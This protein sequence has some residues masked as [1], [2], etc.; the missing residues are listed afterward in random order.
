[1]RLTEKVE[2][3]L[4]T[5][6]LAGERADIVGGPVRDYLLGNVPS[7]YDITTSASPEKIKEIFKDH[8]TVDTGIKHGTVSL[9]LDGEQYEITTYRVDGEYRDFRHPDSVS[10]T[11]RIED[12]LSRRDFTVNA[13]AYSKVY[14]LTDVF[15]GREDLENKL[16]RAVGDPYARFSE[17]AL[18]ILRAIRFSSVLGFEIEERTARAARELSHLLT[19][20]SAERIY[21]EWTKL[22]AGD[23]AYSVILRYIDIITVFLPE[24]C[25]MTLPDEAKFKDA[26]PSVRM[27][28]LFAPLENADKLYDAAMRSLRS[29]TAVREDGVAVLSSLGKYKEIGEREAGRILF[30]LGAERALTFVR[31]EYLCGT[32]PKSAEDEITEFIR[33]GKPYKL[34]ELA[35]D[36]SAVS[37]TGAVGKEIGA[38]LNSLMLA[39]ID[40]E[41]ENTPEALTARA[42]A[43]FSALRG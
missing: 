19:H 13:M 7:D 34:K 4:D 28:S 29:P 6:A 15:G 26:I 42:S 14:G 41:C 35:I 23:N 1:M 32:L 27:L 33:L 16:I 30:E 31:L 11:T 17:D 5:I 24:I 39:V 38:I 37:H 43:E 40:G 12:D 22:V 8:R 21:T 18:R 20:I 25:G 2:Y 3:I 36:G 10:F 9:I